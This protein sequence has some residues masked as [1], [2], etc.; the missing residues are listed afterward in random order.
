M[1]E[2]GFSVWKFVSFLEAQERDIEKVRECCTSSV[3][4]QRRKILNKSKDK[5]TGLQLK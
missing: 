5:S 3:L 2:K 4:Y 1:A